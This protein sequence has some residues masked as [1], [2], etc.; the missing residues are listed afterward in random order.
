MFLSALLNSTPIGVT[1]DVAIAPIERDVVE[2]IQARLPGNLGVFNAIQNR[3]VVF[4]YQYHHAQP[5]MFGH[6]NN[7]VFTVKDTG[8]KEKNSPNPTKAG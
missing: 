7:E 4:I 6:M 3:L 2:V 8:A 5:G 1:A